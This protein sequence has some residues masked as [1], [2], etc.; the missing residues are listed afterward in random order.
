MYTY[1][2]KYI[3]IYIADVRELSDVHAETEA[4]ITDPARGN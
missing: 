3:H 2:Y 4:I 1:M